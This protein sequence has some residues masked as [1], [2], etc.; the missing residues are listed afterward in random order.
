MPRRVFGS[1]PGLSGLQLLN[2]NGLATP[3]HRAKTLQLKPGPCV[4][5]PSVLSR[6][7]GRVYCALRPTKNQDMKQGV[8]I[9]IYICTHTH[10]HTLRVRVADKDF[11][12]LDRTE[13]PLL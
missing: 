7:E 4:L 2:R 9:Y 12:T 6:F 10:T 3:S 11:C 1:C 8:C 5:G 13:N